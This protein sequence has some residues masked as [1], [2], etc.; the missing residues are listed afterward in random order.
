VAGAVLLGDAPRAGLRS[1]VV[2]SDV[3]SARREWEDAYRRF[4]DARSEP[5]QAE[6]LHDQLAVVSAELR[7][8]LGSMFT[9]TELAGEYRR[10]DVW[11]LEVVSEKA[12]SPGWPR[13]V[14]V[15]EGAAFH[16]YARGAVDY[17]P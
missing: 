10:A 1:A 2:T 16:L 11:A 8:R 15:V 5:A 6:R 12:A 4:H 9:L 17:E 14:A 7:R 3:E 13:T